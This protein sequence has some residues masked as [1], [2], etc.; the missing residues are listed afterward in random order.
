METDMKEKKGNHE[1]KKKLKQQL[2]IMPNRSNSSLDPRLQQN[3]ETA[4]SNGH[5]VKSTQRT[6]NTKD[7]ERLYTNWSNMAIKKPR[8]VLYRWLKLLTF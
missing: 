1:N 2:D 8:Y 7:M 6:D 5:C 3:I 4:V